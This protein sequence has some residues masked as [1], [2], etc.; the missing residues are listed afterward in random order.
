M[1]DGFSIPAEITLLIEELFPES[2][3]RRKIAYTLMHWNRKPSGKEQVEIGDSV[4]R[5]PSTV[6]KV[7]QKLMDGGIFTSEYGSVPLYRYSEKIRSGL[8]IDKDLDRLDL[9]DL[10]KEEGE[11]DQTIPYPLVIAEKLLMEPEEEKLPT[12]VVPPISPTLEAQVSLQ[13]AE[14]KNIKTT[15]D[16]RFSKIE[17]MIAGLSVTPPPDDNPGGNPTLP[18][19]IE[20][21]PAIPRGQLS[22]EDR[23]NDLEQ[24]VQSSDG[25]TDPLDNLSA[26]QIR[27]LIRS[28]PQELLAMV[29]PGAGNP[30]GRVSATEV[31][32]RPIIVMMTTYTQMLFEKVVHDGFFDGT[33]SD[34]L[35]FAA[36][37]YFS[38]RGWS[39]DWNRRES[40][41]VR[42]RLG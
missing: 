26:E 41:N 35:N 25:S 10:H 14:I 9:P 37:Q 38:D 23:L 12:T 16:G 8:T 34:F 20:S 3:Q 32:L 31:T 15:I 22:M 17:E 11:E 19:V 5:G 6:Y 36:E 21:S 2:T 39:L 40:A 29:N 13:D 24:R 33:L 4:I 27:E 7:M 42:S 1:S 30:S 18:P 28:Q